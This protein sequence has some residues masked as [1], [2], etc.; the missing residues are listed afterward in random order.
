MLMTVMDLCRAM[1]CFL[2][3]SCKK[4]DFEMWLLDAFVYLYTYVWVFLGGGHSDKECWSLTTM[5]SIVKPDGLLSVMIM[6]C[7][8]V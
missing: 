1:Q 7:G 2:H 3:F 8:I 5:S 4:N 6:Y